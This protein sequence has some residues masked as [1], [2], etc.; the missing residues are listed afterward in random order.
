MFDFLAQHKDNINAK[1]ILDIGANSG[2]FCKGIKKIFPHAHVTSIEAG[3]KYQK[4]LQ[5]CADKV[6]IA[7]LGDE[8]KTVDM[9]LIE[10]K[11]GKPSY[12]K[13]SNLFGKGSHK[14]QRQM[15]LL[16]DI[17]DDSYD[18]IKQDVQGAEIM[19]IKGSREIFKNAKYIIN[20]VNTSDQGRGEPTIEQ[21]HKFMI[22]LGFPHHVIITDSVDKD[23][24]QVDVLYT[25][26]MI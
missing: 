15:V 17:V 20:E 13:G 23:G 21:M 5:E 22:D 4:N 6:H 19:I 26:T 10:T 7:V 11:P 8:R 24:N 2:Q 3:A 25:K 1:K 14:D 12:S 16:S 18:F 9:Y